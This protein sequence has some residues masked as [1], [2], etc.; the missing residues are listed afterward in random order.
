ME[1]STK[2]LIGEIVARLKKTNVFL[3]APTGWGKTTLML[4]VAV[5][6]AKEGWRVGVV[7]PTLTLL[8]KKWPQ[9]LEMLQTE[10]NPPRAILTAGA[11]QYCVYRWNIPQRHCQ[12]CRLYRRNNVEL[13]LSSHITYEDINKLTPENLCGYWVQ[14]AV[15]SRYDIILGH[16][17][18]LLKI[19]W[20][21]NFLFIDEAHEMYQPRFTNIKLTEIA[22]IL[23]IDVEQLY[24]VEAIRDLVEEK[25]YSADPQTED[26][27]WP[28]HHMLQKTCWIE[29][30]TLHC[31][32][33]SDM[34]NNIRIFAVTATPPPGWPPREWGEKIEIQPSVK[35]RAFIE[36]EVKFTYS[37]NYDGASLQLYLIVNWLRSVFNVQSIAVFATSSLRLKLQYSLP[38]GVE[39]FPAGG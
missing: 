19:L 23:G 24:S 1:S 9:L 2:E 12:R 28:I 21:L 15:L 20:L 27:L 36:P 32:D 35:P 5:A 18:R 33:V 3:V 34:P 14:E 39:L 7:A 13:E 25:L 6:L 4:R 37:K 26:R 30:D 11:G 29:A 8:L 31:V 38:P 17:G 10:P 22:E 16:Y